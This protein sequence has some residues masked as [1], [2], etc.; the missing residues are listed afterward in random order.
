MDKRLVSLLD[1]TSFEAEEYRILRYRVEQMKRLRGASVIA[2]TSPAIGDGKTTTAINLAGSLAQAPG[3]R[4]LLIDADLR[5][6][7][8]RAR[9]G[10]PEAAEGPGLVGAILEPGLEMEVVTRRRFPLNLWVLAA[11]EVP[12]LPFELLRSHR[13]GDLL[14]EARQ[15]YDHV[16][17]DTPPALGIPDCH[18]LSKWVDGFLIVVASGRT[19][20]KLLAE[21]LN[22]MDPEKVLGI[23]LND[24]DRPLGGYGKYYSSYRRTSDRPHKGANGKARP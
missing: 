1:P 20:R 22:D 19:P 10:L 11:G 3:S 2:I 23:V 12:D 5:R 15:L 4:V 13:V 8:V 18:A 9:L 24:D 16:I 21:A 17:V 14:T 7:S 6:P